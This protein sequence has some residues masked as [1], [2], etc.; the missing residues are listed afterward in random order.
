MALF[1]YPLRAIITEQLRC[2]HN[3][4]IIAICLKVIAYITTEYN[5]KLK[6]LL[7]LLPDSV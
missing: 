5:K 4:A 3:Y 1:F 7:T 2:Y 6:K